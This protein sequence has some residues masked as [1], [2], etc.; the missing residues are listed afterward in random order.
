MHLGFQDPPNFVSI[1]SNVLHCCFLVR[2]VT[3]D[4]AHLLLPS[5]SLADSADETESSELVEVMD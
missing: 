3:P 2:N 1:T 5:E 4:M